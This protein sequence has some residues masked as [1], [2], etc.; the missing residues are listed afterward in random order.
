LQGMIRNFFD[1][2]KATLKAEID[3]LKDKV[4]PSQ[5]KAIDAVRKIGNIGAHMEKDVNTIVDITKGEAQH[6][7]KL[8][9]LLL[10]KWYIARNDE[11]KLFAEVAIVADEKDDVKKGK[12]TNL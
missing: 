11:E 10:D 7:Q 1:I 9:E 6:L 2:K 4:T 5:W 12:E 8:I 3:G